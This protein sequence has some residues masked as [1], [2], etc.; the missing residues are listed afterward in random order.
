MERQPF[1]GESWWTVAEDVEAYFL[2]KQF[3]LM[4]QNHMMSTTREWMRQL[5]E[6]LSGTQRGADDRRGEPKF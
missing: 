2:R 5:D 4:L 6:L 3:D 1:Y